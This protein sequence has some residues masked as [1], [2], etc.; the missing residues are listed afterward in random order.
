M[1]KKGEVE[2][3]DDEE[4]VGG[5]DVENNLRKNSHSKKKSK[6]MGIDNL[7]VF[8]QVHGF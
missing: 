6:W 7:Q 3:A 4:V 5:A 8:T 1:K 2:N